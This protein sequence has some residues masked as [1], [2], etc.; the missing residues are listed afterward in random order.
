MLDGLHYTLN[1]TRYTLNLALCWIGYKATVLLMLALFHLDWYIRS[2]TINSR[3]NLPFI[4]L[5]SPATREDLLAAAEQM[6]NGQSYDLRILQVGRILEFPE[7][8]LTIDFGD[9]VL[10]SDDKIFPVAKLG[11]KIMKLLAGNADKPFSRE[12][13]YECVWGQ[14]EFGDWRVFDVHNSI[15]RK[16]IKNDLGIQHPIRNIRGGVF[17]FDSVPPKQ[18]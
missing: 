7:Y 3:E 9:K 12:Q 14:P 4:E 17:V 10:K 15:M 1:A 11:M 6:S 16:R 13:I 2:M 8:P 18:C 5:P